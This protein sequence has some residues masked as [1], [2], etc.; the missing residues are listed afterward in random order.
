MY[1][2]AIIDWYSRMILSWRLSNTMDMSFCAEYL[3]EEFE[4]FGEP[5]YFN[6]DQDI[7]FTLQKF[8][9][10]FTEHATKISMDSKG[11][12]NNV[13]IERF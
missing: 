1:L 3:Q 6:S 9:Q 8:R 7:Q 2:V 5:E 4:Q 13:Y 11:R 12:W 10:L